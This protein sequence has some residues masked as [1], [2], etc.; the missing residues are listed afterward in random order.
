MRAGLNIGEIRNTAAP[1]C[2]RGSVNG[3][4]VLVNANVLLIGGSEEVGAGVRAALIRIGPGTFA[5]ESVERLSAG[6]ERLMSVGI[7]AVLVSLNL[8]DCQ[9][10]ETLDRLLRAAPHVPILILA[11]GE[12]ENLARQVLDRGAQDYLPGGAHLD[13]DTLG[14][15]LRSAISRKGAEDAL[16]LEKERA[17]VTLNSIGDAVLST[18]MSGNVTYLNV[19]AER[20]MGWSSVEAVGKKL[21]DVFHVVDR[22]THKPATNPMELAIRSGQTVNLAANTILVRRDGTKFAIEDS[23][24]PIRDRRGALTGAVIV[25]HDVS[26]SRAMT[27]K[28]SHLA[29]HDFLTDLPNRMLF[30]DRLTQAIALAHRRVKPL[31]VLFVDLDHF[32]NINDSLGHAIGDQLLTLVALRLVPCVRECDTVS[33]QG[34]DE[35]VVLLSELNHPE[36]AATIATKLRT[37]LLAPYS[38]GNHDLHVT[39]SIGIS[40]Y[41]DDGRDA[42]TMLRHADTAMYHAKD[43]GRNNHQ[44]FRQSMNVRAVERQFIEAGLRHAL[45]RQEFVVFYQPTVNLETGRITG[46]EALIRWRHPQRGLLPPA[47]FIA[48][49]EEA[50]LIEPI[51]QWVLREACRQ[52][53]TWIDDG[54]R[55]D[56]M[57]VNIS[58]VE[59]RNPGCYEAV[60][61][62]VRETGLEPHFLEL[63]LTET[64]LLRNVDATAVALHRL[65]AMGIGIAVDDFGT[66]YSSLS[67][68]RRFPINTL[69]VDRSFVQRVVTAGDDAA[70]VGAIIAM[71]QRL[72]LRVVAEGVETKEQLSALQAYGCDEGQGYYFGRPQGPESFRALVEANMLEEAASG[73]RSS[74]LRVGGR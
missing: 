52:A 19:V 35:F 71:G 27:Q 13:Y 57:A 61:A 60:C 53:R 6:I 55:F 56:R 18:D 24:A 65:S 41:P 74:A 68:L 69:K 51:G 46:A 5:L 1:D 43:S 22:E 34:G 2:I 49:A 42:E 44:F 36:D 37:A 20:M 66:G 29:Q 30:N 70:I 28:M 38:I 10:I 12:D 40:V 47:A 59:F 50:G 33:R 48:V 17:Q 58:A 26:E 45:D 4:Q 23:A 15:A 73:S 32:K 63:D 9:G 3:V 39:A 14:R 62:A 67:H 11:G 21:T 31:A 7:D 16:F 72:T 25:F 64:V 54:L 8:P